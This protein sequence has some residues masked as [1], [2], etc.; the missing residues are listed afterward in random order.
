MQS[1]HCE[2]RDV[3]QKMI[4]GDEENVVFVCSFL[5]VS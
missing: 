4:S 5:F 3:H 1:S 2:E